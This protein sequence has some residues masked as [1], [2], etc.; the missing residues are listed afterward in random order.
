M[1]EKLNSLY[2]LHGL[3]LT[4]LRIKDFD[5]K[6]VRAEYLQE[7]MQYLHKYYPDYQKDDRY[8]QTSFKKKVIFK[9]LEKGKYKLVLKIYDR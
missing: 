9:L 1:L 6:Q 4:T 2:V 5:D 3:D 8:K 7:N